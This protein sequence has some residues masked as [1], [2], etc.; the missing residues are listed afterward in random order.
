MGPSLL[1]TYWF[2]FKLFYW[3]K[4]NRENYDAFIIH[5]IWQFN[6]LMAKLLLKKK[7]LCIFTWSIRSIF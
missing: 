1:G 2:S 7:V 3:L 4:N 5:G 6:T